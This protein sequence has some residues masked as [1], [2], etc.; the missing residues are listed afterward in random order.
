VY[1]D[2]VAIEESY[3]KPGTVTRTRG[4]TG[5]TFPLTVD[6]GCI[7]VLGDNRPESCDSRSAE[8]GLIDKREVLGKAIFLF[9]PGTHKGTQTRDFSRI[10]GMP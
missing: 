9:L 8:M 4:V 3:L 2:G 10:G 1:V 6:E 7:F 5:L